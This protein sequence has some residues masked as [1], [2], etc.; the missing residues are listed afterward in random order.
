MIYRFKVTL[1]ESKVFYRTYAV[2]PEMTL[3]AFHS[4]ICSDL[5]FDPDQMVFFDSRLDDGSRKGRYCLFDMGDGSMDQVTFKQ[6]VSR[7]EVSLRYYFDMRL[8]RYLLIT[9][10]AQEENDPKMEYPTLLEGKGVNPD[11]FSGKYEDPEP[12]DFPAHKGSS[13]DDGEFDDDDEEDDEDEEED[14]EEE[15]DGDEDGKLLV[16]E[17]FGKE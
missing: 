16:D 3:Y 17:D 15:E 14:D 7:G 10:E 13:G 5:G 2:G 6:L 11:Q 4:F 8:K 1:P 12:V 9:F